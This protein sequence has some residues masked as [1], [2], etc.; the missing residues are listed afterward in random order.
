VFERAR[1]GLSGEIDPRPA[2]ESTYSY[3][4]MRERYG[5]V[6]SRESILPFSLV[7]QGSLTDLSLGA[8]P[9]FNAPRE[10]PDAFL[11]R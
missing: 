1:V 7:L 5:M 3:R 6:R 10:T 2:A 4:G 8:F 9:R 11:Y